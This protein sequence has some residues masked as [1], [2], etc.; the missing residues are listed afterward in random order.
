MANVE[1]TELFHEVC[2]GKYSYS[3]NEAERVRFQ[4]G[5]GRGKD[6]RIYECPKCHNFHLTKKHK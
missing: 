1:D 4:V 6:L 3:K 2:G 5:K